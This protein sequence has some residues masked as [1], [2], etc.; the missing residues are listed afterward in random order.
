MT[1][2]NRDNAGKTVELISLLNDASTLKAGDRGTI[3]WERFDGFSNTIAVN[4][5]NGSTLSLLEGVDQ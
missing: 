4:W 5:H 2:L 3:V 1:M